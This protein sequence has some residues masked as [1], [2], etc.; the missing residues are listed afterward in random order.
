MIEDTPTENTRNGSEIPPEEQ[1]L[2][3]VDRRSSAQ[4]SVVSGMIMSNPSKFLPQI[5]HVRGGNR[6]FEH[7]KRATKAIFKHKSRAP[8][9]ARSNQRSPQTPLPLQP[10]DSVHTSPYFTSVLHQQSVY[11]QN[12]MIQSVSLLPK[13][14]VRSQYGGMMVPVTGGDKSSG[15]GGAS[16]G[17]CGGKDKVKG[18]SGGATVGGG[19]SGGSAGGAAGVGGAGGG[20]RKGGGGKDERDDEGNDSA[21]E[22]DDEEEGDEEE[23]EEEEE[24]D[25]CD[26]GIRVSE[27]PFVAPHES[28]SPSHEHPCFVLPPPLTPS[29][30]LRQYLVVPLTLPQPCFPSPPQTLPPA[31]QPFHFLRPSTLPAPDPPSLPVQNLSSPPPSPPPSNAS[32]DSAFL[33][34]EEPQHDELVPGPH[35]Q[36]PGPHAQVPGPHAQV[37]RPGAQVLGQVPGPQVPTNDDSTSDEEE[38]SNGPLHFPYLAE[39]RSDSM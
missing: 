5:D 29:E 28:Q 13:V 34:G 12:S 36:F 20:G 38:G 11:K 15:G 32:S 9:H 6:V 24:E 37:P 17:G 16:G 31:V 14:D 35:A 19:S 2:V 22:D 23:G 7:V 33:S 25:Q 1:S 3:M 18:G 10:V 4:W 26:S 39:P 8:S 30:M 27:S 21:R